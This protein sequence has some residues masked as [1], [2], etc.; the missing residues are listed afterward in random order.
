MNVSRR[1]V[2]K[3]TMQEEWLEIQAAQKEPA[4]FRPLYNRYYE[5]IFR[6]LYQRTIDEDLTA[7]LCSQVFLKAMQRLGEYTF[8]GVPFSAWLYRIAA[9]ELAQHYRATQKKRVVGIDDANLSDMIEEMEEESPEWMRNLL[10]QALDGLKEHELD[11]IEMRFFEQR[12]FRE[13]AELLDMT[14]N[15]AKVKTY[16]ILER[17]KKKLSLQIKSKS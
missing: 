5:P 2:S 13:I 6:Y 3:E 10:V 1:T 17:L 9:N 14:E 16:R 8:M 12:S 15:N 7:D 4:R 11:L